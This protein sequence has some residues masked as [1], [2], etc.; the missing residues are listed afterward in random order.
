MLMQRLARFCYDR[1]RYVVVAWLLGLVLVTGLSRT[2]GG[3]SATTFTL[4]GTESQKTFDLLKQAFPA[5]SG[6]TADI[7]FAAGGPQGVR[8]PEG[9]QRIAAALAAAQSASH[10]VSGV[11][12]PYS[13]QGA[14]QISADGHVAF[15]ELQFDVRSN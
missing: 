10:H 2:A 11:S 6:D 4:P 9:Q 1:R 12:D 7:V 13:T 15:A 8:A 5:R 3:K 14:R